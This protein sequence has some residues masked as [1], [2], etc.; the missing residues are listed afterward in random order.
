MVTLRES[1]SEC[2]QQILRGF[3]VQPQRQLWRMKVGMHS[4]AISSNMADL[5][6]NELL[7]T[8]KV[9]NATFQK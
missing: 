8:L 1:F 7:G 6:Y 5:S 9:A 2:S 3:I 4:S